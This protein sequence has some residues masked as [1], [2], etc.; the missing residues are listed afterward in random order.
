M[1]FFYY[2][3][4]YSIS[5][6]IVFIWRDNEVVFLGLKQAQVTAI[7]VMVAAVAGFFLIRARTAENSRHKLKHQ[8]KQNV[9]ALVFVRPN[10]IIYLCER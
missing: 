8:K 6:I 9:K 4:G 2:I 1:L 3:I 7:V 5:Q 10:A